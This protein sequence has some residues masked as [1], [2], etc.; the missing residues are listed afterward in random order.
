MEGI[1]FVTDEQGH[2]VAVQIDLDRYG[3]IWED[4]YDALLLEER[5]NEPREPFEAVEAR[6][7]NEGKLQRG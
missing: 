2:K 5:K 1:R 6:L 4:F 7:M 3:E